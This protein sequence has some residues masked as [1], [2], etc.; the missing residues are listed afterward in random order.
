VAGHADGTY[1]DIGLLAAGPELTHVASLCDAIHVDRLFERISARIYLI[2]P[3]TGL[4][5]YNPDGGLT[6]SVD[7]DERTATD[8]RGEESLGGQSSR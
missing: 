2:D 1:R 4:R 6:I 5:I 3:I 7:E 8:R